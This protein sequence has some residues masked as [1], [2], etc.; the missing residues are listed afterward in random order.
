MG[1]EHSHGRGPWVPPLELFTCACALSCHVSPLCGLTGYT[2]VSTALSPVVTLGRPVV[3]PGVSQALFS[4]GHQ[5]R[6]TE[7]GSQH[8][9]SHAPGPAVVAMAAAQPLA[10]PSPLVYLPTKPTALKLDPS[11]LWE[12]SLSIGMFCR[13]WI[14]RM[15]STDVNPQFAQPWAEISSLL[16]QSHGSWDSAGVSARFSMCTP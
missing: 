1:L 13:C 15:G 6:F 10:W 9:S 4:P 12:H 14:Y 7:G 11:Q 3:G 2:V 5:H 8:C 16:S